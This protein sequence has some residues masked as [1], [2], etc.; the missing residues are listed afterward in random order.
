M[1]D[2]YL[3]D[4]PAP[5]VYRPVDS[6]SS[7]PFSKFYKPNELPPDIELSDDVIQAYGRAMH[8]LGRL[9]GFWS[10]IENPETVFGLFVY[11]EAEQ[12]SQVE[13]T[14]VTVSDMYKEGSD[15][16][17]VREAR[18]YASTLS[19]AA[20]QLSETGRSRENLS[21]ELLKDLHRELMEKGRTDEE[22]P[23]PGEFRP[24][25]AWIDESTGIGTRVRFAPPK[26]E[27]AASRMENVEEYMQSEGAY[28]DLIDIGIL[29]YQ[30]ETIHPFVDGNGRV[31]RLLIVLLLMASD[32]LL[33][34]LFYLSSYIRR[35]RDEYT[36]RLLAVSEEGEWNEWLLF[37]LTGIKEQ[38][39]EAFSRAKLLLHLHKQYQ[40]KYADARPSVRGLLEEVFTEPVFTVNRASE[41]IDMS[42]PAANQAVSILEDDGVLRER[43]QKERYREF[44]ADDVLDALNKD[45][46]EI[47]SPEA[48]IEEEENRFEE[49]TQ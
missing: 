40:E 17:D 36:N 44:Q 47:P 18:N 22:D 20:K 26:A 34:P 12:S 7:V 23:L 8:S 29:H 39:N 3:V 33:H 13:G 19:E 24:S 16:K 11:K 30:I 42:Y 32:I 1:K 14:R 9:D 38:A 2:G 4:T 31:G 27:I 46:D 49:V 10:E 28:P 48:V 37:F 41:M 43:T 25:Y 45:A 35:N 5:G 21:N 6:S 15:S